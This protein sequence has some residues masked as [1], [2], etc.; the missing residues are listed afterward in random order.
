MARPIERFRPN[1]PSPEIEIPAADPVEEQLGTLAHEGAVD[2]IELAA[3][4][5]VAA[6]AVELEVVVPPNG[7]TMLASDGQQVP[8]AV[9]RYLTGNSSLPSCTLC[10]FTATLRTWPNGRRAW[11]GMR[12]CR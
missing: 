10:C 1:T 4:P 5:P 3:A 2:L 6:G 9:Q 11:S 8:V 7:S 12:R